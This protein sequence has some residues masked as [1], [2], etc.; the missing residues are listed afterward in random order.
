MYL[1]FEGSHP[2]FKRKFVEVGNMK[3]CES[4]PP[5]KPYFLQSFFV[6]LLIHF[7]LQIL[8][9]KKQKT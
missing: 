1:F 7:F 5:S 4:V 2:G 3:N 9:L 8:S 6:Q